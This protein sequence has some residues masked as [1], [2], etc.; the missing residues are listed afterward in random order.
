[1][2]DFEQQVL[3]DLA[4]LKTKMRWLVGNGQPGRV[5]QLEQRVQQ[6]EQLLQRA[7]GISGA[8]AVV[9]ALLQLALHYLSGS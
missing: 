8:V 7:A 5:A 1:M 2:T 4:E 6:H 9:F 3:S